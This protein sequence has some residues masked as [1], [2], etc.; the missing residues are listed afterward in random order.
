MCGDVGNKVLG[1][2]TAG[3]PQHFVMGAF[4]SGL[5]EKVRS[6]VVVRGSNRV[7]GFTR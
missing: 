4:V 2:N 1:T 7:E 3:V 6:V 5:G